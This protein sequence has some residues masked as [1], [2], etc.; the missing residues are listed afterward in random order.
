MRS[1]YLILA[2]T[3][4]GEITTQFTPDTTTQISLEISAKST[5]SKSSGPNQPGNQR[6]NP[7]RATT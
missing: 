7:P 3:N 5:E 2:P 1:A 6:P 4:R